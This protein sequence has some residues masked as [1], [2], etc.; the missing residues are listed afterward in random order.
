MGNPSYTQRYTNQRRMFKIFNHISL[1]ISDYDSITD[2]VH[3]QRRDY[4]LLPQVFP[5]GTLG[6]TISSGVFQ[7]DANLPYL[8]PVDITANGIVPQTVFNQYLCNYHSAAAS[9]WDSAANQMHT[10]FFGGISQYYYQN[11]QLIQDI[12]VPFVRTISR[13]SRYADGTLQE[14]QLPIEMPGLKGSSAEFIPNNN[15]PFLAAGNIKLS[16][17][18]ADSF[19]VRH[20]YGGI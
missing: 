19:I 6:L 16:N 3:L 8:Y 1:Y 4:N 2:P 12:D 9:L 20:V 11:S 17:I 10:L 7:T 13:L 14:F 5:D 15:L 18:Q